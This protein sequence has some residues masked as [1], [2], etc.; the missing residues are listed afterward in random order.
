[1]NIRQCPAGLAKVKVS[2][3][4]RYLMMSHSAEKLK[5]MKKKSLRI[6]LEIMVG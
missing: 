6:F 5:I 1:M 3:R 4:R 2:E